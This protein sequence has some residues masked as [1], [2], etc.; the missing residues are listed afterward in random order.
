MGIYI[1][2]IYNRL[3]E[4]DEQLKVAEE[5]A[6]Y[7][8]FES[9]VG[10]FKTNSGR[11]IYYYGEE[12]GDNTKSINNDNF[13]NIHT[14]NDLFAILLKSWKKETAYPSCQR[15]PQYNLDNDPTY[16][17][18]AITAIIVYDLF[19]GTIHRIRVNSGGTHYFNKINGHYIDLTRDQFDLYNIPVNY[20]PN[21]TIN[22]EYCGKNSDTAKR[23]QM[24]QDNMKENQ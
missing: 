10:R 18:C 7:N 5:S 20:E 24:L 16:G 6:K 8:S 15:D 3:N 11:N 21:E 23:L 22:R 14:L 2:D 4:K 1:S 12:F 19:G 17:Q 13:T 9:N